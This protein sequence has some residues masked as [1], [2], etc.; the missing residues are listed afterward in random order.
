MRVLPQKVPVFSNI[1]MIYGLEFGA[2]CMLN[3]T[4]L[5]T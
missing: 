4:S 2:M 3:L 1:D 5:D